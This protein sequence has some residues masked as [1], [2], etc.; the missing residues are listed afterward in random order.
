MP[1][2]SDGHKE[3]LCLLEPTS[4]DVCITRKCQRCLKPILGRP[5]KLYCSSN[6]RKRHNEPKRN[7]SYSPTKRREQLEFFD[8]ALRLAECLYSIPP[9]QRLGFLK[10]LVDLAREGDNGQLRLILTNYLLRHPNPIYDRH[11]FHRRNRAYPTI[12]QAVNYY[13]KRFWKADAKLVV[14]NKVPEPDDGVIED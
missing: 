7:A 5:N 10:E 9:N 6:C 3:D 11:L 4:Q 14:Y 2:D 1:I 8:R 12:A 13:C